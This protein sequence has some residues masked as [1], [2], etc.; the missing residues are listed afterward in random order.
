MISSTATEIVAMGNC[1]TAVI[2]TRYWLDAQGCGIFEK[3]VYQDSKSA[4]ILETNSKY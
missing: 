3:I 4:I 1:M 2:L